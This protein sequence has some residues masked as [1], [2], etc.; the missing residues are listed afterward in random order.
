MMKFLSLEDIPIQI[1][2]V[3]K[4]IFFY[5]HHTLPFNLRKNYIAQWRLKQKSKS[6][7]KK[8]IFTNFMPPH[9][10]KTKKKYFL[11]IVLIITVP[12]LTE[13]ERDWS[14]GDRVKV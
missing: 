3:L 13:R 1:M 10:V 12:R 9:T 2:F 7:A 6:Y 14:S 8:K 11:F 4:T 5:L